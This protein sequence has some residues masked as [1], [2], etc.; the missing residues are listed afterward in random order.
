MLM[1]RTL[2]ML[3]SSEQNLAQAPFLCF[4]EVRPFTD[5]SKCSFR[6]TFETIL[7]ARGVHPA[8][9]PQKR[10]QNGAPGPQWGPFR[11]QHGHLWAQNEPKSRRKGVP[12]VPRRG[13]R[14]L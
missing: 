4:F 11:L 14:R 6:L 8:L 3:S 10:A 2:Q 1:L 12:G 7:G 13:K 9:G 5:T